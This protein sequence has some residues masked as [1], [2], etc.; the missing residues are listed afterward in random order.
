[1]SYYVYILQSA[2]DS[3]YYIGYTSNIIRRLSEH[4][5]G[6]TRYTSKKRPWEIVY[7][8][9]FTSKSDAIK[10]EKFLKQQ[11]NRQ[12]YQQLIDDKTKA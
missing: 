10:R 3:S 6:K 4:N 9:D 7:F 1:M 2:K 5:S 8:E 11:R 12:F